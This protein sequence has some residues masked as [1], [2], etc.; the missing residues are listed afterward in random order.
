MSELLANRYELGAIIGT[1][2]MSEVYSAQDTLL[3][4]Q[5]AIKM[6]RPDLA[7]DINFRERFRKEAKNSSLLNHP[8]I[9]ATY[10]TG[11]C[12]QNGLE[13][14]YIVM[15]LI[16]GRTLREVLADSGALSPEQAARILIP[17]CDALQ[18]SHDTGII[19]RDIKPANIMITNTGSAKIMDFGIA[20][21]LN[22]V[23]SAMTQT[24]TVIGTA[25]YLSP[26]QARGKTVDAR[27]DVYAL[28]CVLYEMVTAKPPF[29]GE[30]PFSV[31]YQHVQ[32][33]P[34][35]PSEF[36]KELSATA[37]LNIDAVVLTAMAKHPG[38]RYQSTTD[39]AQDLKRLERNAVTEAARHYVQPTHQVEDEPA[40][41][42]TEVN[43]T[44]L[45]AQS[46][47]H[48][49][50]KS[51]LSPL[52][53]V[54]LVV[55][56]GASSVIGYELF[57]G[58]ESKKV[59]AAMV[60][61]PQLQTVPQADAVKRLE[62]LGLRVNTTEE[63]SQ[64]IP[65][66]NVI[67]TNPAFGSSVQRDSTVTLAI[68]S[69]KEITETPDLTGLSI[70]AA[71]QVLTDAGLQ[72]DPVVREDSSDSIPENSIMEQAPAAGSQVS[73]G[74]KV[75]ITV[76]TGVATERIPIV[77]GLLRDQAQENLTALGFNPHIEYVDSLE[78]KDTVISVDS[79]GAQLPKGTT[80]TVKVSNGM[81]IKMPNI[82]R[83]NT[84][85]ALK[86]LRGAGWEGGAAQLKIGSPVKTAVIL[87]RGLIAE[88]GTA[89][90]S[91]I[92]K[93]AAI[94]ARLY[95]FDILALG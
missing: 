94:N 29:E 34:V 32:D 86:A 43:T 52:P 58:A 83:L 54:L 39:L 21:A 87:D 56:L 46:A 24:S 66:G 65:R 73:K 57:Q 20:R 45:A 22:D 75:A 7:R 93:D 61:I 89:P 1:G 70:E 11:E 49:T 95:E 71:A 23:T 78:P 42:V 13:I 91:T 67:R 81:L 82:T 80:V 68:S 15:E 48:K 27:S 18:S 85:D 33:D 44:A 62:Q 41:E 9:V 38:D 88:Q 10:D 74:S 28:G 19:H 76:S 50:K 4:R 79:E 40:A 53:I 26:E 63:A 77:T 47:K 3:G 72:L 25:Q 31:A 35:A 17:V 59:E 14:P 90:G 51:R 8:A 37:A 36:L 16:T 84:D 2:G 12:E 92:R 55:L 30:S 60:Q 64:D 6:L 5:V 69:G